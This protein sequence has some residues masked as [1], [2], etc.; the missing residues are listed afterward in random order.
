MQTVQSYAVCFEH[1]VANML[2]AAE[3]CR[4]ALLLINKNLE[5]SENA[6]QFYVE[7]CR[8]YHQ[9]NQT[10]LH[11]REQTSRETAR[12]RKE[13]TA[14]NKDKQQLMEVNEMLEKRLF[15]LEVSRQDYALVS[16]CRYNRVP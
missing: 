6:T 5:E 10:L 3:N 12:L 9:L 14:A 1:N 2:A 16:E 15:E 8:Q 7:R 13:L 11:E 4:G